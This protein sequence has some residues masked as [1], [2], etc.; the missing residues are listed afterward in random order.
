[1]SAKYVTTRPVSVSKDGERIMLGKGDSIDDLSPGQIESLIFI[2]WAMDADSVPPEP[3]E[4][5]E[6]SQ[7][8]DDGDE[9]DA[10]GGSTD[11]EIASLGLDVDI[12]NALHDEGIFTVS[13]AVEFLND[14][15]E[16]GFTVIDGIGPVNARKILTAIGRE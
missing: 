5:D 10:D 6:G 14:S 12:V 16:K 13:D 3:D 9:G 4:D 7:Q 11:P 8:D 15:P 2:G 1:M